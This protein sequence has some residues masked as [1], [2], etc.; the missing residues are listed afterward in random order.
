MARG[1]QI[2]TTDLRGRVAGVVFQRQWMRP[3]EFTLR[4]W[5]PIHHDPYTVAQV[6]NRAL[7]KGLCLFWH[8]D[9]IK[10]SWLPYGTSLDP[11]LKPF[12]A[13][14]HYNLLQ[15]RA[16]I[17]W[18][19]YTPVP[20]NPPASMLDTW[21]F[22]ALGNGMVKVHLLMDD[23]DPHQC[24]ALFL[25]SVGSP[26]LLTKTV[27]AYGS[28][29]WQMNAYAGIRVQPGDYW[30]ARL[31]ADYYTGTLSADDPAPTYISV[32]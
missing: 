24:F 22:E 11:P 13:F 10:E 12:Q 7:F 25:P 27:F 15:N 9:A 1:I 29:Y 26:Q 32:T 5:D 14:L 18:S 31:A 2:G 16:N 17:G 30:I 4:S 3:G 28:L 23:G 19:T 20:P 21:E 6:A 8:N